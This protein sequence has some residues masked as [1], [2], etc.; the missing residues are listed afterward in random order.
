MPTKPI[1]VNQM[2]MRLLDIKNAGGTNLPLIYSSDDE[3]NSYHYVYQLPGTLT[4]RTAGHGY[5]EID[6]KDGESGV[7]PNAVIIN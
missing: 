2:L 6:E 1:T 3:G 4:I 5:V 7:K